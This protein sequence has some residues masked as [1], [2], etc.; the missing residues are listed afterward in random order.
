MSGLI[1]II[2]NMIEPII[3]WY[4]SRLVIEGLLLIL[5]WRIVFSFMN[6]ATTCILSKWNLQRPL[7]R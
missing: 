6:I 1:S 2:K 7:F 4:F 3:F 5:A